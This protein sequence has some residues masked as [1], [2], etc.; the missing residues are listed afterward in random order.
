MGKVA[1]NERIKLKATFYNNLSAGLFVAGFFVPYYGLL[2]QPESMTRFLSYLESGAFTVA[3]P[4]TRRVL[5]VVVGLAGTAFV[6]AQF[7]WAA[8]LVIRRLR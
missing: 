2:Q 8:D 5:F 4:G 6:A 7:R 1:D 3:D